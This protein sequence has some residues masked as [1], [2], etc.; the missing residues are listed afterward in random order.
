LVKTGLKDLLN[1]IH[2]CDCEMWIPYLFAAR[3]YLRIEQMTAV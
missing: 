2:F 1:I 3:A